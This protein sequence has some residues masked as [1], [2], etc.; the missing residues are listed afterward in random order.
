MINPTGKKLEKLLF[1]IFDHSIEGIDRY[2]HNGSLWLIFTDEM[3]WVV[4]YTKSQT[5]WYNYHFFKNEMEIIGLDC[6]ENKDLIQKWFELRFLNINAVEDT[7]PNERLWQAYVEDTIQ[8]GVKNTSSTSAPMVLPVEDTIKNGVKET[9]LQKSSNLYRIEDTIQEGVKETYKSESTKSISLRWAIQNGVKQTELSKRDFFP[10]DIFQNGVKHIEN[11]PT[12]NPARIEDAIQNGVKHC[13]DGDWLDG[14]ERFEDIIQNGV[15][16]M[17]PLPA[18]DGNR[19]WG[20][21]YHGKEDRT[22]PHTEYVKDVIK[23][24]EKLNQD[25]I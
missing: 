13:E 4:E 1:G 19:D 21:Y 2:N 5:L 22:K 15:K 23:I 18:Q 20:K 3:R 25:G 8:N 17:Q 14:D 12:N 6:V 9:R 24:C 16:E 10:E 7:K 11:L